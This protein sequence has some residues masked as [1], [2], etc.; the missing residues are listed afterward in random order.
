M[1]MKLTIGYNQAKQITAVL[2]MG[3]AVV[4]VDVNVQALNLLHP[5]IKF[6]FM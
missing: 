2:Y 5:V 1:L 4:D 3:Y 6:S